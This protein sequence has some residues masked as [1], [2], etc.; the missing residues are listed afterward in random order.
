MTKKPLRITEVVLRDGH[1]SLLATR[2][3]TEHMLPIAEKMDRVGFWSVEMWGGATFDSCI[4]FLNENPWERVRALKKLMPKTPF[5]MLLRGQ[6]L[7]GYR[8]YADDL[9]EK[10]VDLSCEAGID[11]FRVFDALNDLRNIQTSIARVRKNGKHAQG[12]ISYTVS[13]VHSVALFVEMARRLED[14]GVDTICVKDM[15]GLLA[16]WDAF[17]LIFGIKTAVKVPVHLHTHATAGFA[18]MTVVK[19]IEVGVDGVDTA[20]ASFSMGTSHSPTETLVAALKGTDNDTGLDLELLSEIGE[21]FAGVRKEYSAF[22]SAFTGVDVNILK[23]QVPG[24]MI[25]NLES[26]LRQ[27]NAYDRLPEVMEELPRCRKDLGYPPLVTPTSQIVGTQAVMNVLMGRY[28]TITKETSALIEGKYGKVPGDISP[29]LLKKVCGEN[30]PITVRPADLLE[31]EWDRLKSEVADKAVKDEDVIIFALFPQVAE[32]YMKK[33]GTPPSEKFK[34]DEPAAPAQPKAQAAPSNVFRVTVNGK[35]YDVKVDD[36]DPGSFTAPMA[37][38][39]VTAPATAIAE[40]SA[41]KSP[42]AGSIFNIL[43][44]EGQKVDEGDLLI[45]MEAMKMETEVHAPMGGTVTSVAVNQ[46]D[47]VESG[48]TLLTIK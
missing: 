15:A 8:H 47:K 9:V 27:Q 25:S 31:P 16:P 33:R 18:P 41:V 34:K 21:Y 43:C 37:V 10:F 19:A 1:Q 24:G 48:D 32:Q 2:M 4:R 12:A 7:V 35:V 14:M 45:V 26:Q 30:Q 22:E 5:Q 23:S 6:N 38:A 39:A 46:G 42:L 11:V 17:E 3:K 44:K 13:P 20:M 28:K 29:E 36:M 40:G